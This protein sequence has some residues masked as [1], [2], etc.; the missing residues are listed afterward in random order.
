[1]KILFLLL[2]A[3]TL[4]AQYLFEPELNYHNSKLQLVGSGLLEYSF[5]KI[6]LYQLAYY[7]DEKNGV[8]LLHLK[9]ARD[10]KA[11]HSVKGWEF[12]FKE[13]LGEKISEYQASI[14]WI[15]TNTV[16]M[17]VGDSFK[18]VK[19]PKGST[20]FIKND[21]VLAETTNPQIYHLAHLPWIGE[22]PV[23][24]T[25]KKRLIGSK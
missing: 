8:S 17:K 6:D 4:Y 9:Y 7:Q 12:A 1:M 23:D 15:F 20:Q 10:I 2:F 5:L 16:D 14:N 22:K 24:L 13:N 25:V 19:L 18:I 11:E 3:K 21:I